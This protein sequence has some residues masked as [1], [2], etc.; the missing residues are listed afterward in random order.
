MEKIILNYVPLQ[1]LGYVKCNVPQDVLKAV[2][3]EINELINSNFS[4][5]KRANGHLAGI[6]EKEYKLFSSVNILNKFFELIIPGYWEAVGEKQYASEKYIINA[7]EVWVN[8]QEKYEM[9]PIHT[10]SGILSFVLYINIPYSLEIERRQPQYDRQG[11][12]HSLKGPNFKF[13]FPKAINNNYKTFLG[14][15]AS[16]AISNHTI[17]VDKSWEGKMTIFPAYLPHT[18]TPFYSCDGLRISVAGNL[19]HINNG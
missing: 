8:L 6:I 15:A 9:N 13:L 7:G 1:T 18:V 2:K 3:D 11:I 16:T 19:V 12:E 10:H 17:C 4:T 5:A 14:P